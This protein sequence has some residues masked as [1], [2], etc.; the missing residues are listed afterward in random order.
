MRKLKWNRHVLGKEV[1]CVRNATNL[2]LK[3]NTHV[4][5][6]WVINHVHNLSMK[7]IINKAGGGLI[8]WCQ[9]L[10]SHSL[11][12]RQV[13]GKSLAKCK[14]PTV[15]WLLNFCLPYTSNQLLTFPPMAVQYKTRKLNFSTVIT[16]K[17]Y[18][19]VYPIY[20][21]YP[22]AVKYFMWRKSLVRARECQLTTG[23]ISIYLWDK[24]YQ[25]I[26]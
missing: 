16:D 6:R 25:T 24:C 22:W 4:I 20:P 7:F 26:Q 10:G 1:I 2:L 13:K 5:N 11:D 17:C 8:Y 14:I 18:L 21:I 23:L 15:M 19:A 12:L 3:L 9:G